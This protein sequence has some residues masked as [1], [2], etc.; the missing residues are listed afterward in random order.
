MRLNLIFLDRPIRSDI[1]LAAQNE[2]VSHFEVKADGLN[3]IEFQTGS[4]EK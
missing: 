1:Y 4:Y 2:T 3:A